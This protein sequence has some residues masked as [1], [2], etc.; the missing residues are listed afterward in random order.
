MSIKLSKTAI[1]RRDLFRFSA[2]G[3][4]GLYLVNLE[5]LA[6]A[7]VCDKLTVNQ[8]STDP[9]AYG[10]KV[11]SLGMDERNLYYFIDGSFSNFYLQDKAAGENKK[12]IGLVTSVN[13]TEKL[14]REIVGSDASNGTQTYNYGAMSAAEQNRFRILT[15]ARVAIH[16]EFEQTANSYIETVVLSD[17]NHKVLGI[18]RLTPAD[19]IDKNGQK[20]AP[21]IIFD[22]LNLVEG[23]DLHITYVKATAGQP[24]T[25]FQYKIDKKHVG[26]SR[27]DYMHL[28]ATARDQISVAFRSSLLG[29]DPNTVSTVEG[30][31]GQHALTYHG[32]DPAADRAAAIPVFPF[33]GRGGYITTAFYAQRPSPPHAARS[34]LLDLKADGD[35]Q[36]EIE[37]MHADLSVG[38]HM[39]YFLVMDPVG[40]LMAGLHRQ[41]LG[42]SGS[43]SDV[44][45][46][47]GGLGNA[48]S[49]GGGSYKVR[50]GVMENAKGA[51]YKLTS[52]KINDMPYVQIVTED[53]LD[54]IARV[55][56]RLR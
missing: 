10:S 30:G 31:R 41:C 17:A 13:G 3:A 47:D 16:C 54:A 21:Y 34:K 6:E 12:S 7:A 1:D 43:V 14:F 52:Y 20:I 38:H 40:R 48:A 19:A 24:S 53:I 42:A 37:K 29:G 25:I 28:P 33:D 15:K 39:R 49:T 23:Q 45:T 27:F 4:A 8:L 36:F 46:Y 50:R 51:D 55:S 11:S 5:G 22:R 44:T 2:M 32:S 56:Y 26:P 35:F 9:A 18:R